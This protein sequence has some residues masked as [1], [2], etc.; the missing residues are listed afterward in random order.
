MRYTADQVPYEEYRTW[1]LCTLLHCPPSALDD[2]SALTLDWL[3]A[4]DDT[5]SKLR[6]DREKEAARG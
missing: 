5:V 6:S 3:L 2:E 1:R 4:V